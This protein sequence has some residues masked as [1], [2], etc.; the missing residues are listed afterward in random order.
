MF[1]TMLPDQCLNSGAIGLWSR[2]QCNANTSKKQDESGEV[3][4]SVVH[5]Q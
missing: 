2:M 5:L 1:A 3:R 4:P